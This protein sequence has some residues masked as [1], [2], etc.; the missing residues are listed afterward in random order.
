M[1]I[2]KLYAD[3]LALSYMIDGVGWWEGVNLFPV[4]FYFN[5][6]YENRN[7]FCDAAKKQNV[8]VYIPTFN[9]K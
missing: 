1:K 2:K 8:G 9:H 4:D 5:I 6:Q 7:K 3:T